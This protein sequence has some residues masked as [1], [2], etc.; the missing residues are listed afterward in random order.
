MPVPTE[1]KIA[2]STHVIDDG[3]HTRKKHNARPPVVR[4]C[5]DDCVLETSRLQLDHGISPAALI[6]KEDEREVTSSFSGSV[7]PQNL[8]RVSTVR[9]P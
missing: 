2:K 4:G 5:G 7:T 8:L 1:Q 6:K 3:A 9:T